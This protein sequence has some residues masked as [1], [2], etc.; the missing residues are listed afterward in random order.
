[1][2]DLETK[3]KTEGVKF[4]EGKPRYDL[5]P[6]EFL[7]GTAVILTFGAVKYTD[8]NWELGMDWGRPFAACMRH[9]WKWW[10]GEEKDP[11]S[12]LPHLWHAACNIAFLIT[13]EQR[14]VGKDTRNIINGS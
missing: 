14:K 1:M 9:L 13:Y 4:D 5:L 6:M 2:T 3:L 8:R 10:W 11:E 12:G 7:H